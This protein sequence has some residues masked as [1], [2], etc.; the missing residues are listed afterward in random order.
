MRIFRKSRMALLAGLLLLTMLATACQGGN[1]TAGTQEITATAAPTASAETATTPQAPA[2][3]AGGTRQ[4]TDYSGKEITIPVAPKNIVAIQYAGDLLALGVKPAYVTDYAKHTYGAALDGVK[5][6]GNRPVSLENVLAAAPDLILTDDTGDASEGEQLAKV[7]PTITLPFWTEDPFLH[8]NQLAEILGKQAEAQSW[9]EQYHTKVSEVKQAIE[10]KV[11]E[12]ETALLLIISGKDMGIS[13]IRNGGYTL[14][15]QLGFTPT[16]E[17]KP[18]LDKNENFGFETLSLEVLPKYSPDN[19][20]VEMDDDSEL[21]SS[22]FEQLKESGVWK[23]LN[24][25]KNNKVYTV[26]NKWGLGDATSLYAQ[27]EEAQAQIVK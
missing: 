5:S 17:M 21:T 19:L 23:S 25:V 20:F 13:G 6:I 2:E 1:N 14:Y 15:R 18:L 10:P 11:K 12:G 3:T 27:L 9:L 22:T 4:Y 24:A 7:G 8:F 26:T 16:P